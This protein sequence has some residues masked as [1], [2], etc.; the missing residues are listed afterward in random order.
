MG[1]IEYQ[2]QPIAGLYSGPLSLGRGQSP[3]SVAE[4]HRNKG[5]MADFPPKTSKYVQFKADAW[6]WADVTMSF[7]KSKMTVVIISAC[8][9][10]FDRTQSWSTQ[11]EILDLSN[12]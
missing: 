7:K 11:R 3:P 12:P 1:E 5:R 8:L 6:S 4:W 9:C 2:G 10:Y